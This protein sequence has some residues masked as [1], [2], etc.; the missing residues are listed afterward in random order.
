[1]NIKQNDTFFKK[2]I[3]KPKPDSAFQNGLMPHNHG[4]RNNAWLHL[5]A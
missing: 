5:P 4:L 3:P 2:A 1:M